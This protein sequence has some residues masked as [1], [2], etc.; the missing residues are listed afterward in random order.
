MAIEI[1]VNS[2]T[3]FCNLIYLTINH[4]F[5]FTI[6]Q[7]CFDHALAQYL[8]P[9]T[10]DWIGC[11]FQFCAARR[12]DGSPWWGCLCYVFD[13]WIMLSL[14]GWI[15]KAGFLEL[16]SN[17]LWGLVACPMQSKSEAKMRFESSFLALHI[18]NLSLIYFFLSV[19]PCSLSLSPL[20]ASNQ[21]IHFK[22]KCL[23]NP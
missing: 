2:A 12:G 22:A 8:I 21:W 11:H 4:S 19:S 6:E 23:R 5:V 16:L 18:L 14:C 9:I 15:Y 13:C 1:A 17:W 7:N 3:F 20:S 10:L